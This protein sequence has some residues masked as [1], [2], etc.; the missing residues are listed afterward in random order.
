ML[1]KSSAT[2]LLDLKEKFKLTQVSLQGIIQGVTALNH[3]NTIILKAQVCEKFLVALIIVY[4]Y[5]LFLS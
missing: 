3:Q 2:F 1:Q 4:T 5:L